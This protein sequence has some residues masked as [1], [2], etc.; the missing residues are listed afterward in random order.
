MKKTDLLRILAGLVSTVAVM[1]ALFYVFMFWNPYQIYNVNLL[2]WIP[3]LICALSLG[4]A[5]YINRETPLLLLPVLFLPFAV[6]D[7]FKFFYL[8]FVLVLFAVGILTLAVTRPELSRSTKILAT[9]SVATIFAVFLFSQPL[10]IETTTANPAAEG[11]LSVVNTIWDFT[12]Q[13]RRALPEHV[14]ATPNGDDFHLKN[15]RGKT[16]LV[17]IWATWC[18]PCLAEKPDLERLKAEMAD[19]ESVG[20]LDLSIDED[21]SAWKTY[22]DEN[23]PKGPQV[24]ARSPDE[25]RRALNIGA[26]PLH[27]IV[28]P[29]GQY[30]TFS[31]LKQAETALRDVDG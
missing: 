5:G 13:E 8:P 10:R 21:K 14:L 25:T 26:L 6:F 3:I 15:L 31:S 24:I 29:D 4:A 27:F 23:D 16:H 11:D 7:L 2:K 28:D 1:A 20:F 18:G 22:L 12:E 17:T 19:E 30:R 9:T